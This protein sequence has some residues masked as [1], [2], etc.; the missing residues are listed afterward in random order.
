MRTKSFTFAVVVAEIALTVVLQTG[1]ALLVRSLIYVRDQTASGDQTISVSLALPGN[2][3]HDPASVRGFYEDALR[4]IAA[5]P[6][7]GAVAATSTLPYSE[8]TQH[9]YTVEN[10]PGS[11]VVR[12]SIVLGDYLE[13]FAIPLRSGRTFQESDRDAVLINQTAARTFWPGEDPIGKRVKWGVLQTPAPWLTIVGVVA[14]AEQNSPDRAI[15][16]QFYEPFS[17]GPSR[18]MSIVL[19]SPAALGLTNSLRAILRSMDSALPLSRIQTLDRARADALL[20]RRTTTQI[21]ASFAAA[22]LILAAV[23][24][25][26]L[27]FHLV[28]DRRREIAIRMALGANR[29]AIF[30]FVLKRGMVVVTVGFLIGL[31]ASLGLRRFVAAM[32]FGVGSADPLAYTATAIVFAASALAALCGPARRASRVDANVVLHE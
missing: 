20:P 32:I 23:G 11:Q 6:G 18:A 28:T 27:M 12:V 25:Y 21:V 17:R 8:S 10:R 22:A 1:A 31:A 19:R 14:D 26:G 30:G 7:V 4:K 13:A 5:I 3:Y 15:L 16:P 29:P 9:V 2:G 24:I